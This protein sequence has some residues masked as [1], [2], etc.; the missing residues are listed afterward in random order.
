MSLRFLDFG[1]PD[2]PFGEIIGRKEKLAWPVHAYRVTLPK[3]DKSGGLNMFERVILKIIDACGMRDA[4]ALAQEICIPVELVKIVLLRLKD[5]A[6]IDE[7]NEIINQRRDKWMTEKEPII[8]KALAFRELATGKILPFL[9]LLDEDNPLKKEEKDEK[10][11]LKITYD[12]NY[13]RKKPETSDVIYALRVM[14]KRSSFFDGNRRI[15]AINQI[16]IADEPE[17][18][19]LECLIAVQKSDGEFRIA[20]PFGGGFSL[21]LESSFSQ[22]LG[23]NENL[24]KWFMNW[25]QRLSNPKINKESITSKEPFD[26]DKN[27]GRY[28]KLVYSLRPGQKN[29]YRSI[30][31]IYSALE[32]ALFYSCIQRQYNTAIE[33]L[34]FTDSGKH[35]SILEATAQKTGLDLPKKGFYPV[36][37]GK[38]DDFLSGKADMAT[39][40]SIAL[41]IAENDPSHPLHR[42]VK[43]Y[44]DFINKIFNIK[45][46]RDDLR[47]GKGKAKENTAKLPED[48]FMR[49][50][51]TAL[52]PDIRFS[53]TPVA[54]ADKDFIADIMFD[55]CA[56]IQNEF[57]LHNYNQLGKNMQDWLKKAE[58]SWLSW[59][60]G[61]NALWF[62]NDLYAALQAMFRKI[63]TGTLPP[64]AGN[65]GFIDDALTNAMKAGLVKP[66]ESKLPESLQTVN[67]RRISQTLQGDNQTLGSCAIAFLLVYKDILQKVSEYQPLF[68]YDV[69]EIDKLSAHGNE[70]LFLKKDEIK[71]IRKSVYSTI[72]TLLEVER[73]DY[74]QN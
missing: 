44:P 30:G 29:Q 73:W 6:F 42:I 5:M 1:K 63:L 14:E 38:L 41:L 19:Y 65:S 12:K 7:N 40:I 53:D 4:K 47:H 9:H 22:L 62:V 64:D 8:I 43:K 15:P 68:I 37:K 72:K 66:P 71:K 34:K 20:N 11:F 16:T 18:Y 27:L 32:W 51:V 50:I 26:N 36:L 33:T 69:A 23:H 24:A 67:L 13:L 52:L 3:P 70:P 48:A 59:K 10:L 54:A 17:P 56:N 25:K 60:D 31:R 45:E 61:D 74:F 39:V 28:G 35:S 21:I 58:Q 2:N 55:S 49:E 46:K 57:G